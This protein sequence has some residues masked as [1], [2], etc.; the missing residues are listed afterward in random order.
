VGREGAGGNMK[1]AQVGMSEG[2]SGGL[3]RAHVA[4][5]QRAAEILQDSLRC[6]QGQMELLYR[7]RP[8]TTVFEVETAHGER[9]QVEDD[10][11]YRYWYEWRPSLYKMLDA[12]W[13]RFKRLPGYQHLRGEVWG[14]L[15]PTSF[16]P[17]STDDERFR[18]YVRQFLGTVLGGSATSV[19]V[20]SGSV[21]ICV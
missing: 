11:G 12:Q 7:V 16:F 20:D 14:L 18:R 6:G 3:Y 2:D 17:D 5:A 15:A 19:R 21:K 4:L 13:E 10:R 8:E 9:R 1:A